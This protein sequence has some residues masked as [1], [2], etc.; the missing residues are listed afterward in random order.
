[1]DARKQMSAG[2][3]AARVALGTFIILFVV[4]PGNDIRRWWVYLLIAGAVGLL[5]YAGIRIALQVRHRR[6]SV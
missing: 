3:G 2:A 6:D 4:N 1:M 5:A